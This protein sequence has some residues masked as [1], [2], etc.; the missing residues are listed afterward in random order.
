MRSQ[1][2]VMPFLKKENSLTFCCTAAYQLVVSVLVFTCTSLQHRP[3]SQLCTSISEMVKARL[4]K[5][6][7]CNKNI[8]FKTKLWFTIQYIHSKCWIHELPTYT[9]FQQ[10]RP[11]FFIT[12]TLLMTTV[13]FFLS[14]IDDKWTFRPT[15]APY[16]SHQLRIYTFRQ[17]V[18]WFTLLH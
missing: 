15:R 8:N 17:C 7:N 4:S 10:H 5:P 1:K 18:S 9:F 16:D 6:A 12:K 11:R 13:I 2:S 14:S 3:A